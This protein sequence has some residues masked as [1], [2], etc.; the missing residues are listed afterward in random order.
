MILRKWPR[1]AAILLATAFAQSAGAETIADFY[2]GKTVTIY[3][4]FGPGG[5]YDAYGQL[6]GMHIGRHIP[7]QPTV[8]VKHMP[9][10]GSLALANY[11]YKV[12][13]PDGT[14]F[15]IIAAGIAF[16]PLIGSP[17][18]K[19]AVRF[20][21]AR[22]GWLGSL[23]KFTP[24]GI[25]WHTSGISTIEDLQ[26]KELRYGSTGPASGAEGYAILLNEMLGTKN[27]AIRGYRGSND[28]T[29]AM[30]KG[31]VDGFYGWC[32]TCMK[33][34]RPHY[35]TEKK[36]NV[37]VQFGLEPEPEMAAVPSV[38]DLVKEPKDNQAVR[39]VLAS[40]VMSRPFA[41]PPALPAER[42]HALREAF[43]ATAQDPVFLA[44]A[45]K[46]GRDINLFKGEQIE[47]LLQQSHALP[48][49]IVARAA[50]VSSAK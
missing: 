41:A 48:P 8:I 11:L 37:L 36:V 40:L 20:D 49:D 6:L 24:I 29:L 3:V 44:A 15:G 10:A 34:D 28:I 4:G 25:A 21:P 46:A 32:W 14:A 42:L 31:E 47:T 19:V 1:C 43:V 16:A 5:G 45:K 26:K 13:A 18:E 17:Q 38:L 33:A 39:L 30:E 27:K 50:E 7:G 23:E 2:K 12:A 22:F 35:I 9:G